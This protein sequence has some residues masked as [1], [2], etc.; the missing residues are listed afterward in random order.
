[1]QRT[2]SREFRFAGTGI[3]TGTEATV[4]VWPAEADFGRRFR[5]G[6]HTFPARA[7]Y[8]LDPRRCTTLGTPEVSVHTGEH[9][10]SALFAYGIDNCLIEVEG[11]EVPILDGSALPIV[12]AIEQ[13]GII[14]QGKSAQVLRLTDTIAL[15]ERGSQ[16]IANPLTPADLQDQF[17]VET[18]VEFVHWPAGNRSLRFGLPFALNYW[19]GQARGAGE[20][21]T[22]GNSIA[23]ART[24]AFRHE[25]EQL[26]A[27]GLARGGSLDNALIITPSDT[28]SSPLRIPD[29]WCAHKTL[30]IIG[31]LSLVG[32]RLALSLTALRPGHGPNA[33]M[34]MALLD[35]WQQS[36]RTEVGA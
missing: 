12:Q 34:A 15:E 7:D 18:T 9:L 2:L 5:V 6:S 28:F 32:G 21:S 29:E 22:Y 13:S 1:M 27:A 33:K 4:T 8:V 19:R 3:H 16:L 25:V 11:P 20:S 35:W 10:L 30:D 17:R 31:D 24:F 36:R 14:A 26:L 23:P